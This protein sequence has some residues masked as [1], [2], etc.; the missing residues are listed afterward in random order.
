MST[1]N[2][3]RTYSVLP[4]SGSRFNEN[5]DKLKDGQTPCAICG[6]YVAL[7][8]KYPVTVVCGGGWARSEEEATNESDL[9]F[10][11]VWGVGPD[12]HRK[13]LVKFPIEAQ[14]QSKTT[15]QK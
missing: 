11:G 6:K 9:G 12:C 4:F 7:P 3:L 8:Y 15:G 2:T 14:K 1:Q 13:Y 10:M 5:Q